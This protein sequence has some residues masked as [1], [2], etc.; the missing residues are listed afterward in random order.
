M[1]DAA[2]RDHTGSQRRLGRE[3]FGTEDLHCLK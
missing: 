1:K 3:E 2:R